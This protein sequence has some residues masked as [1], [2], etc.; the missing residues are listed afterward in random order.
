MMMNIIIKHFCILISFALLPQIAKAEPFEV[1]EVAK[2]IYVHEGKHED[3]D[4]DYHGDIANIG[5]IIGDKAV[6]V[7]D[8]GGSY[9]VGKKLREAVRTVTKLPIKY[10]INTH[11][12][13]DH[14]FGNAAFEDDKPIFVGHEKL[15]NEMYARQDSYLRNLKTELGSESEGSRIVLPTIT[16]KSEITLELGHRAIR[17]TR[18]PTA[19]TDTDMT[20]YDNQTKTFWTGDLLFAERTPSIDGDIKGWIS[21]IDR[22]KQERVNTIVPGHGHVSN[23]P[24]Q[25][26]E[27]EKTY[28]QTLLQDVRR[29]IKA[30]KDMSASMDNAAQSEKSK[31]VLFDVVNRRN[32]NVLYPALE[33]EERE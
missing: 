2:G 17:L 7:V 11:V 5:F 23:E 3:F 22:L 4:T 8:T 1:H 21:L 9:L 6:A 16:V 31:W 25:A 19:H 32:V 24:D 26:W 28:L 15:P 33:W 27:K 18:W 13:P 30:G 20:V 14:I 10:V 12:H 29:D